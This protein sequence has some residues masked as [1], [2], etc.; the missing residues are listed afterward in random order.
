M[1][2]IDCILIIMNLNLVFLKYLMF[3][4]INYIE[5][6]NNFMIF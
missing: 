1:F 2:K 4:I 6:Y 3:K 5:K